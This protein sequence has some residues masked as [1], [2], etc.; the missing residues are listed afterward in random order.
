MDS[1]DKAIMLCNELIR[2][3]HDEY[4]ELQ[5]KLEGDFYIEYKII[6]IKEIEKLERIKARLIRYKGNHI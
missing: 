2:E 5:R 1:I 3:Y 4:R 6:V